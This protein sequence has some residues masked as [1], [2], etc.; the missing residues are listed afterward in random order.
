MYNISAGKCPK[1]LG[2]SY[3]KKLTERKTIQKQHEQLRC[4]FSHTTNL[5]VDPGRIVVF[6][7]VGHILLRKIFPEA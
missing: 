7:P 6:P 3:H 2:T 1:S 5:E 4:Y